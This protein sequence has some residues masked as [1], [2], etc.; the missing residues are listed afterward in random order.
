MIE[1]KCFTD[2][3]FK[4]DRVIGAFYIQ[5]ENTIIKQSVRKLC[6]ESSSMAEAEI[7][8]KLLDY[9][10]LTI[11]KGAKVTIHTDHKGI[12]DYIKNTNNYSKGKKHK[13]LKKKYKRLKEFYELSIK[14]IPRRN[15]QKADMLCRFG[16]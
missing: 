15:N 6:A 4:P 13:N 10:A 3:S 12:V 2:A 11:E 14:Y 1:Y 8:H 5:H 16:L 7:I 9:I